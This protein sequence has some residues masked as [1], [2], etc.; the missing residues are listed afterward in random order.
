MIDQ[1]IFLLGSWSRFWIL[2]FSKVSMIYPNTL[3]LSLKVSESFD[4]STSSGRSYLFSFDLCNENFT[5]PKNHYCLAKLYPS[6][7]HNITIFAAKYI[8]V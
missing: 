4:A 3:Q 1:T 6:Y 7:I 8:S 5:D 2:F